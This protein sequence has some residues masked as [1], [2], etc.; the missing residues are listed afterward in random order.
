MALQHRLHALEVAIGRDD[1]A[2]CPHHRLGE[3]G[4][5]GVR[6]L[7]LDQRLQ[8]PDDPLDEG[9]L[10]L[11][12][13][14]V[15]V[16]A[17]AGGVQDPGDRQVEVDVV[18][19]QPGQAGRRDGDAVIA[20]LAADDLLLVRLADGVVVVPDQLDRLVVGL[21]AGVGEQHLRE[22]L[23]RDLQQ[24]LGQLDGRLVRAAAEDLRIGQPLHLPRG[25]GHQPR[26]AEAEGRAPEARQP[27]QIAPSSVVVD[28]AAVARGDHERP[29][30]LMPVEVRVGVDQGGDVPGGKRVGKGA[31]GWTALVDWLVGLTDSR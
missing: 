12:G 14:G 17:R 8:L 4:A 9:G 1:D 27:L 13:L 15:V 28:V 30:L 31:H 29:H 19:G 24:R 20:A 11:A 2:P 23:R 21:R 26:L 7:A 10:A 3:E 22:P 18:G 6:P 16:V 5:D 25:G